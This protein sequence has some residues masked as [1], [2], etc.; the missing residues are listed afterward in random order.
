VRK[1]FE[2]LHSGVTLLNESL[3]PVKY[4]SI[5]L[6]ISVSCFQCLQQNKGFRAWEI[7]LI[8]KVEI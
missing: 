5:L 7:F 1:F 8:I 6:L 4:K 3:D 2:D